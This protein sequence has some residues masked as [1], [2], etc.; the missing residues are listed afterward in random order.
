MAT[1]KKLMRPG[2]WN[3]TTQQV[4]DCDYLW[5]LVDLYDDGSCEEVVTL[6]FSDHPGLQAE[7]TA[8]VSNTVLLAALAA[9]LGLVAGDDLTDPQRGAVGQQI[10]LP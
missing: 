2:E 4:Q 10:D 9:V 3:P 1:V 5:L 7:W 8:G 6:R